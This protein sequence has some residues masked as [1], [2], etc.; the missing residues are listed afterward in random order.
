MVYFLISSLGQIWKQ[1][2]WSHELWPDQI[3]CTLYLNM[4]SYTEYSFCIVRFQRISI[5]PPQRG[6]RFL[7]VGGSLRSKNLKKCIIENFH[8]GWE[9][10]EKCL[11]W[12][13]YGY[14]VLLHIPSQSD[15]SDLMKSKN[16]KLYMF[17]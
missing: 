12:G 2:F 8:K 16:H 1:F 14:C 17:T 13:R 6:L 10:L 3:T 15:F 7:G 4:Y 11:S 5:L 9:V